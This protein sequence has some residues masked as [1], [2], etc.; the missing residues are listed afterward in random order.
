MTVD[1]PLSIAL[2]SIKKNSVFLKSFPS[3]RKILS[4]VKKQKMNVMTVIDNIVK[5]SV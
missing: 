1:L 4:L 2:F 5:W 3:R